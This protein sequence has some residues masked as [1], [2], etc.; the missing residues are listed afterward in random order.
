MKY[1]CF[2]FVEKKNVLVLTLEF[3]C[4]LLMVD[5]QVLLIKIHFVLVSV[6]L[7]ILFFC[8]AFF[9]LSFPS[10]ALLGHVLPLPSQQWQHP[11]FVQPYHVVF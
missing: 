2:D 4:M 7:F 3:V 6:D 5:G 1:M 9:K 8:F 11:P 10:I